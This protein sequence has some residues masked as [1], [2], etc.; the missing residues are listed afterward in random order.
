MSFLI[1]F[2]WLII[3]LLCIAF[4]FFGLRWLCSFLNVS[5]DSMLWK[6]FAAICVVLGLIFVF[7]WL[8]SLHPTIAAPIHLLS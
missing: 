7:V 4:V 3:K 2:G 1:S 6:I 8:F 5:V